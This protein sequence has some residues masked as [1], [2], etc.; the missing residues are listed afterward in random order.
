M[1]Y[2]TG[3]TGSAW[4]PPPFIVPTGLT[5][6]TGPMGPMFP[7]MSLFPSAATG[8]VEPPHIATLEELMASHGAVVTKE[9]A[10]KQTLSVL[11]TNLRDTLRPSLF[12]WA[13]VGFPNI[14][15]VQ[16][17]TIVPPPVCSDGVTRD[18]FGYV[19]YCLGIGLADLITEIQSK[20]VGI[21]FSHSILGNTLRLHVSTS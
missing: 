19:N 18:T 20:V 1:S 13:A 10:D 8:T 2:M 15:V 12:Q 14:Y 9:A 16:T 3:Y 5:G 6:P 7:D 17:F 11:K 21:Q 4:V